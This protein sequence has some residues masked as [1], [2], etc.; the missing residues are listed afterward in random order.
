MILF[1]ISAL[2]TFY[3]AQLLWHSY[4]LA[5]IEE[6]SLLVCNIICGLFLMIAARYKRTIERSL[7]NAAT[8]IDEDLYYN[9]LERKT[10]HAS[11]YVQSAV[12]LSFL[13]FTTGFIFFRDS[14]PKLVLIAFVLCFLA[15]FFF[16]PNP[17]MM[18][19]TYPHYKIP[20]PKSKDPVADT[21]AYYDDG[22]KY[23]LLKSLYRLYFFIL[24][25]FVLLILGL[26]YYS[27]FSGNNQTV[28]ILGI[29]VILLIMMNA[30]SRSLKPAKITKE[31]LTKHV[32]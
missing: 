20:D 16:L 25:A 22:Q 19:L 29:G 8:N 27:I 32:N 28:S 14:N 24:F 11:Y 31:S 12:V 15:L 21:L 18:T 4:T 10:Y 26:M 1:I 30:L 9:T 23:L 7:S 13:G 6:I 5:S 17:K 3:S 2:I